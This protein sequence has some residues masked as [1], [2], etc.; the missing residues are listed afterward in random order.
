MSPLTPKE[1][2]ELI[3]RVIN[4]VLKKYNLSATDNHEIVEME[5][6]S[7][8]LCISPATIKKYVRK[9]EIKRA[10]PNIKGYRF[11]QAELIRFAN[12]YRP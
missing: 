2:E 8:F 1:L 12:N 7:K 9:K 11:F 5:E 10:M 6:A 3:T 4:D